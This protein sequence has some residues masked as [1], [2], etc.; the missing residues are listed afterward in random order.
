ME[1]SE[2]AKCLRALSPGEL[3][4]LHAG[5]QRDF[6]RTT[7]LRAE[8]ERVFGDRL[9]FDCADPNHWAAEKYNP[10][11]IDYRFGVERDFEWDS[12]GRCLSVEESDLPEPRPLAGARLDGIDLSGSYLYPVDL[13]SADL[14][15]ADLRHAVFIDCV[16]SGASLRRADL[17]DCWFRE[18]KLD[19]ADFYMAR[20]DRVV[21]VDCDARGVSFHRAKLR[22]ARLYRVD[23]RR[24]QLEKAHCDR[25]VLEADLRGVCL[26]DLRLTDGR[27]GESVIEAGQVVPLLAA[28]GIK[29][30]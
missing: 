14:D 12:Y 23:L 24:A 8:L 25:I 28:L 29:V 21:M 17:R 18:C 11:W 19:G 7:L 22:R 20:M 3:L 16:L 27:V 15:G 13:S 30:R 1:R 10:L 6:S 9:Q 2:L 5:G 4:E 26:T